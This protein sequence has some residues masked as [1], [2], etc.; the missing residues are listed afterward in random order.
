M[1]PVRYEFS[2]NSYSDG[3]K[4]SEG[5]LDWRWSEALQV[6]VLFSGNRGFGAAESG[7]LCVSFA[8]LCASSRRPEL[9]AMQHLRL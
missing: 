3:C 2:A 8:S 7:V 1:F 5:Y 6:N 4:T 9:G